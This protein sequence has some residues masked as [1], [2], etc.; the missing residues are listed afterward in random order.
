MKYKSCALIKIIGIALAI[1]SLFYF[2]KRK[3]GFTLFVSTSI[4]VD[5]P[6]INLENREFTAYNTY[7]EKTYMRV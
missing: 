7:K 6:L 4:K 5:Y 1:L 2:R 3:S